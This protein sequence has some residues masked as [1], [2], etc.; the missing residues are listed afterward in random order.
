MRMAKEKGLTK[1]GDLLKWLKTESG[2][3]QGHTNAIVL[4][5]IRNFAR[6]R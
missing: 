3:G 2:L 5:N 1:C 6:G 4:Y